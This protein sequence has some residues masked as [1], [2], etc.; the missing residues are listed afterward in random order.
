VHRGLGRTILLGAAV[1]SALTLVAPASASFSLAD[2]DADG[3]FDDLERRL[4]DAAATETL[5][6]IV[7]LKVPA[8]A[9][10]VQEISGEVDGL[11]AGVRLPLVNAFAAEATRAEVFALAALPDVAHVEA[12]LPVHALNNT[13]Q[14]SFGVSKARLDSGLNGDGDGSPSTYSAA[15]FVAAVV[16]TGVYAAHRDL[17]GGKVLA[18]VNCFSGTCL[19]T[20]PV[21][22]DGHGTHVAATIAG[23]GEGRTDGLYRGVAPAGALVNVR[24]LDDNGNGSTLGV[25]AALQW[26]VANRVTYGIEV[27][28]LSLG[29]VGC[30]NG[31]DAAS[32]AVNNAAAAGIAV[33]VAAGNEGPGAC[34]IGIPAAASGAITVGAMADLGDRGFRLADFSSRGPTSDGRVKPDLVGPGVGITSALS[35][36]TNGY[37]FASGTSMAS[38]FVAGVA[39]LMLD[40]N[41]ALS[42]SQLK[43]HLRATTIDWGAGGSDPEYGAGRLDAYASIQAAGAPISAPPS[44]PGHAYQSGSLASGGS[45]DIPVVVTQ[46]GL[47]FAATL[48]SPGWVSAA[49]SPNFDLMLLSSGGGVL[50][51]GS[52]P[53]DP[54]WP[55]RRRQEELS[56]SNLAPGSYTLRVTSASGAGAF[57]LDLSGGFAGGTTPPPPPG[58]PP[59]PPP[60]GSLDAAIRPAI[61]G[62]AEEGGTLS[63]SPGTW[64]APSPPAFAYQWRRCD[65]SG[66]LCTDISGATA[67]TYVLGV[68]DVGSTVRVAVTAT[69]GAAS[70]SATSDATALVARRRDATPPIVRAVASSGRRGTSVRLLYKVAE[71]TGKASERMRIYRGA[72]L[73]KTITTRLSA[74]EAGRTYFVF[75][76][77]PR[78]AVRLRFCVQAWDG[79]GNPSAQSCAPLRIR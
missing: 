3:V 36:T 58:P 49:Q 66:T 54:S 5:D 38:P 17:D 56:V 7:T 76:R 26:I 9:A 63:A 12:N 79:D 13:A 40:A 27:A 77:A 69:A 68:F 62:T 15:D 32:V 6:V 14:D 55:D 43:T 37:A 73:I 29:A 60:G 71:E 21:D 35:G 65:P 10:R 4:A 8:T 78:K 45:T 51:S 30:A 16:D 31:T 1:L 53:V 59:P 47:P 39:L 74:R 75:W 42:P 72:R 67:P 64:N 44:M 70:G 61:T 41:P 28:N 57:D 22:P 50:A 52:T 33:V 20:S 34:T 19:P 11:D 18:H 23:D 24:V 25:V 48:T 46:G 2:R